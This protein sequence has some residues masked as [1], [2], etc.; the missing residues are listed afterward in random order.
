M[1]QNFVPVKLVGTK[2]NTIGQRLADE[3]KRLGYN[4]PDFGKLGGVKKGTVIN[5][6]KGLTSPTGE[7]LAEIAKAGADINYIITGE[8]IEKILTNRESAL[9]D[10]YRNS[11]EK[12]KKVIEGVAFATAKPDDSIKKEVI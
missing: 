6:E 1:V 11:N 9:I 8:R 4:Q 2:M 7:F 3:R 5:W 10:N 12:D